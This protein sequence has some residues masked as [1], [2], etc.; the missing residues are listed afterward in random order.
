[1]LPLPSAV[2]QYQ[3]VSS[4]LDMSRK[5]DT[6]GWHRVGWVRSVGWAW[7]QQAGA[8]VGAVVHDRR[9]LDELEAML[10]WRYLLWTGAIARK[11]KS[12]VN[13]ANFNVKEFM[14]IDIPCP[15]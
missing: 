10:K 7:G 5:V 1:M 3:D 13:Q 15:L 14:G 8:D 4:N 12:E 6:R 9:G 11:T 2:L